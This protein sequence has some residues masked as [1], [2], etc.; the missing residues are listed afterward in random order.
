M[1]P[2]EFGIEYHFP[3]ILFPIAC[4]GFREK[5]ENRARRLCCLCLGFPGRRFACPG[6]YSF[7]LQ[8]KFREQNYGKLVE[9]KKVPMA[10]TG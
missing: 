9:L 3:L 2:R 5:S 6:L 10:F 7:A 1:Q 4:H 8:S